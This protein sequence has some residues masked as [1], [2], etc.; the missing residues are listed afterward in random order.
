MRIEQRIGRI[1]RIGQENEVVQIINYA[2][3][4][5]VDGD[6]YEALE[7]RL[8]VFK[9]VVGSNRAILQNFGTEIKD[10]VMTG[11]A[12]GEDVGEVAVE[13]A[14]E[15]IASM[16]DLGEKVGLES[17]ADSLSTRE[18]IID[19]ASLDGWGDGWHP[20]IAAIGTGEKRY[21]PAV[22]IET[23]EQLLTHSEQLRESG[24][25]FTAL[26]NHERADEFEGT[27]R[28]AY[29]LEFPEGADEAPPERATGTAQE[30][31]GKADS[32]VVTFSKEVAEEFSSIRLLL[33]G[34]P[35]YT[36][37]VSVASAGEPQKAEV[38]FG[39]RRETGPPDIVVGEGGNPET[40]DVIGVGAVDE[41]VTDLPGG[42]SLNTIPV[43]KELLREWLEQP[44]P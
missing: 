33:P 6:I 7:A 27:A 39:R 32:L 9:D 40:A 25:T 24:W 29:V 13:R 20:D 12:K 8:E 21:E 18:E 28:D 11:D 4:D 31:L 17:D 36:T 26:R 35:L 10:L 14:K 19:S 37:L 16:E 5:T 38:L 43:T 15:R 2:Y 23:I 22:S 34:D 3:D 44:I 1:D 41:S 30:M 42:R